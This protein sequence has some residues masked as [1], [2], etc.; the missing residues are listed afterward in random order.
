MSMQQTAGRNFGHIALLI[1]GDNISHKKSAQIINAVSNNWIVSC[2]HV[3]GNSNTLENWRKS[4]G[5]LIENSIIETYSVTGKNA[6]DSRL[7][8]NAT[9]IL[10]S[11]AYQGICI[12]SSD[13]DF[14]EICEEGSNSGVFVIGIG[15]KKTPQAL[16]KKCHKFIY[17]SYQEEPQS[18]PT[19][20]KIPSKNPNDSIP[21]IQ[22][23][24][25]EL[26]NPPEGVHFGRLGNAIKKIDPNFK[27]GNYGHTKLRDLIKSMPTHFDISEDGHS[28]S[29]KK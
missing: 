9:K 20:P 12:V 26:Q 24:L 27:S 22:Q 8:I 13:V 25:T 7:T 4:L 15:E 28:V 1:D 29:L 6:A 16:V 3:Y 18:L 10:L 5:K 23:A 2:C 14:A 21:L 19:S 17:I 11:K